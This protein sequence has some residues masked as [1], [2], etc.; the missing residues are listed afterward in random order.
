MDIDAPT[1][2]LLLEEALD[3]VLL[4]GE[5]E[6]SRSEVCAV[7]LAS[8]NGYLGV[9]QLLE[10]NATVNGRTYLNETFISGIGSGT[11]RGRAALAR[12]WS[13]REYPESV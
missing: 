5:T 9:V 3:V 10:Y 4:G 12:S 2:A 8:R 1:A 11:S 6:A 13:G 7:H